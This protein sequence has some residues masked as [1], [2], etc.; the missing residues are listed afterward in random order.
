MINWKKLEKQK[1]NLR[2]KYLSAKPF[3]HLIIDDFCEK[4][5]IDDAYDEISIV[6]NK[7]RDLGFAK[8]KFEKSNYQD[9]GPKMAEFHS[10][11]HSDRFQRF[12]SYITC[13]RVFVDPKNHGGG[14]HIGAGESKLTMHLDYNYH[15]INE[16]WWRELNI[17][18]YLNKNWIPERGGVLQLRDLRT[19]ET[20]EV[21]PVY[22]RLVIQE[23]SDYSLHGYE[24]ADYPKESPRTSIASYAFS[25]HV[26]RIYKPRL[27]DWFVDEDSSIIKRIMGRNIS[28]ILLL[29]SKLF[30]SGTAR[31]Q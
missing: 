28:S 11:I 7:S 21:E 3:P 6:E 2:L 1:E 30:G 22:N 17:L 19:D 14:L 9:L 18:F 15:P 29:K 20:I 5:M 31:N 26:R 4:K 8:N 16:L 25:Q 23:C 27:T 24:W 12:L 13:K 10:D